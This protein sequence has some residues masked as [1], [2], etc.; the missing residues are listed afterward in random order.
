MEDREAQKMATWKSEGARGKAGPQVVGRSK[1]GKTRL[2]VSLA[3]SEPISWIAT[4]T[5]PV[6]SRG[7]IP[8]LKELC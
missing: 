8:W 2:T 4:A 1:Q 5:M 3:Y 7:A 6:V